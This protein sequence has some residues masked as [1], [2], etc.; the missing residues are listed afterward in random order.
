[1]TRT[2][3]HRAGRSLFNVF[4]AAIKGRH[5]DGQ[6]ENNIQTRPNSICSQPVLFDPSRLSINI[7]SGRP[8]GASVV[9][10][11][12]NQTGEE[13]EERIQAPV[14]VLRGVKGTVGDRRE[15]GWRQQEK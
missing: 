12:S 10:R 6:R 4:V 3:Q 5:R 9:S 2:K 14:K 1:M 15:E 7:H 11:A 13:D 8:S